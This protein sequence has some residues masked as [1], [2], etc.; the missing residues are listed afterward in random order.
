M[1]LTTSR[2]KAQR[3]QENRAHVRVLLWR[4][5]PAFA[6]ALAAAEQDLSCAA[7]LC[8][9]REMIAHR[10]SKALA[11]SQKPGQPPRDTAR[12]PGTGAVSGPWEVSDER[13]RRLLL[14]VRQMAGAPV[15]RGD[16]P[17]VL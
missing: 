17:P 14:L 11:I 1:T 12:M 7:C 6:A 16:L 2:A 10:L 5:Q 3:A 13:S 4:R 9:Q 15:L 8:R